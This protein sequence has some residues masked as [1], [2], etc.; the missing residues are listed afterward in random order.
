MLAP[1]DQK[2]PDSQ[3]RSHQPHYTPGQSFF[4]R[5]AGELLPRGMALRAPR[6]H[7]RAASMV[8]VRAIA[9]RLVSGGAIVGGSTQYWLLP[10]CGPG[11]RLGTDRQ[12]TVATR[13]GPALDAERFDTLTRLIRSR[14]SRRLAVGLAATGLLSIAVP[15]AEAARCNQQTLCPVCRRCRR[16]RCKPDR[17]QDGALC[18]FGYVCDNGLCVFRP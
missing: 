11:T 15:D 5:A 7:P 2:R 17:T 3:L 10:G 9:C 4:E 12:L 6:H 16:H 13:G 1:A 18:G 8:N 14:T